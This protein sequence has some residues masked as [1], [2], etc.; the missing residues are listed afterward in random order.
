MEDIIGSAVIER[1]SK[2]LVITLPTIA[3]NLL[4]GKERMISIRR[5][6]NGDFILS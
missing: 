4:G 6:D 5:L 2:D 1:K 3:F